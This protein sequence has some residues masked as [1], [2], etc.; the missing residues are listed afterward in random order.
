MSKIISD[1]DESRKKIKQGSGVVGC[2]YFHT[3][4]RA[5]F[6]LRPELSKGAKQGDNISYED[7]SP[8]A[9]L[10]V[11]RIGK[12]PAGGDQ[13]AGKQCRG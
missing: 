11:Q 9:T 5:S 10:Y 12:R 13:W 3:E 8:G 2:S 7:P 6:E 4:V 1:S